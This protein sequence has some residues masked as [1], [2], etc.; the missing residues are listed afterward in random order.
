LP[1]ETCSPTRYPTSSRSRR[2]CAEYRGERL[3]R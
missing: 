3:P 2:E 1:S